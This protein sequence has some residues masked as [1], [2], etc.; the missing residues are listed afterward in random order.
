MNTNEEDEMTPTCTAN[1]SKPDRKASDPAMRELSKSEKFLNW[2]RESDQVF[3]KQAL[4]ADSFFFVAEKH[5]AP[6]ELAEAWGVSI[7]TI[8]SIFR[9]EPGVLKIGKTGSKYRRGYVTLR[10]PEDVAERVHRRLSA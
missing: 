1:P 8:R 2:R 3:A 10:I 5:F 7:E 9:E 6:A 4:S